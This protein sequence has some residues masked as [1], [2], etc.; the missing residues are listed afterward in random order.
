MC[1][2]DAAISRDLDHLDR[3]CAIGR[4]VTGPEANDADVSGTRRL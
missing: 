4:A 3:C 2:A 1:V